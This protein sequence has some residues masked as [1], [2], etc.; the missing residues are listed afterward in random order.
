MLKTFTHDV[1]FEYVVHQ[2]AGELVLNEI[3]QASRV[4]AILFASRLEHRVNVVENCLNL[5]LRWLERLIVLISDPV[6]IAVAKV[7]GSNA[8]SDGNL[9]AQQNLSVLVS[10]AHDEAPVLVADVSDIS[11]EQC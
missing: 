8:V 1:I 3:S 2:L 7:A 5:L 6:D 11:H 10:D 9:E 4:S